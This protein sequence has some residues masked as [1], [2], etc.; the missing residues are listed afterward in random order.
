MPSPALKWENHKLA[1]VDNTVQKL[2][3]RPTQKRQR[4][5]P[6][7]EDTDEVEAEVETEKGQWVGEIF[8][9]TAFLMEH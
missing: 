9:V 2:R 5:G 4:F 1:E 3:L 7:K 6:E 8:E